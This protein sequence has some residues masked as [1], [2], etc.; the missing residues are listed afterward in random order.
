MFAFF[1][2]LSN[3]L[4]VIFVTYFSYYVHGVVTEIMMNQQN[5]NSFSNVPK[6]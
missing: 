4:K 6:K 3:Q 5:H 1:L 2:I